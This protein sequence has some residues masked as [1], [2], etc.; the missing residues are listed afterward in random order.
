MLKLISSKAK[1]RYPEELRVSPLGLSS[2]STLHES[3]E[4]LCSF[5]RRELLLK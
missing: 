3:L 5:N 2:I 4:A 1:L